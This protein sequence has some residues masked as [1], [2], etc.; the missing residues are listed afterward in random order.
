MILDIIFLSLSRID[1]GKTVL[2]DSSVSVVWGSDSGYGRS[3]LVV[4]STTAPP[5]SCLTVS[6]AVNE[7][8]GCLLVGRKCIQEEAGNY[9]HSVNA[10]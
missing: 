8:I 7:S 2:S 5:S 9:L 10:V 4:F 3:I 1:P 6:S